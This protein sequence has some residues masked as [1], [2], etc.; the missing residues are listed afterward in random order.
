MK[1]N[2]QEVKLAKQL[3]S[4][5]ETLVDKW[6][7]YFNQKNMTHLRSDDITESAMGHY[8]GIGSNLIDIKCMREALVVFQLFVEDAQNPRLSDKIDFV[9]KEF[10]NLFDNFGDGLDSIPKIIKEIAYQIYHC[11]TDREAL[12][13]N[14][15]PQKL[16]SSLNSVEKVY[17]KL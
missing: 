1:K 17:K 12:F 10:N 6:L 14:F 9:D 13:L 8:Y 7:D 2:Q 5:L 16:N 3:F 4:K 15:N 11:Y